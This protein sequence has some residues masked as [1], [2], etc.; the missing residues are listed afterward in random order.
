MDRS[1]VGGGAMKLCLTQIGLILILV[2]ISDFSFAQMTTTTNRNT[3]ANSLDQLGVSQDQR[4]ELFDEYNKGLP[5]CKNFPDY[6]DPFAL[7]KDQHLFREV[8]PTPEPLISSLSLDPGPSRKIT[9]E[10]KNKSLQWT[11]APLTARVFKSHLSCTD[12]L[13]SGGN[14]QFYIIFN[15]S[16]HQALPGPDQSILDISPIQLKTFNG[17]NSFTYTKTSPEGY[18]NNTTYG[19]Y[20]SG[21]SYSSQGYVMFVNEAVREITLKSFLKAYNSSWSVQ[22][23]PLATFS[24]SAASLVTENGS[25][26]CGV[27][28]TFDIVHVT[29]EGRGLISGGV[30]LNEL[31]YDDWTSGQSFIDFINRYKSNDS[32]TV[33]Y[34]RNNVKFEIIPSIYYSNIYIEKV[35]LSGGGQSADIYPG[36]FWGGKLINFPTI[37]FKPGTDYTLTIQNTYVYFSRIVNLH[38]G[39]VGIGVSGAG[40]TCEGWTNQPGYFGPTTKTCHKVSIPQHEITFKTAPKEDFYS[41]SIGDP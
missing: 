35:T 2:T 22:D 17:T 6:Q 18:L 5:T 29:H 9:V 19:S 38:T 7:A 24:L 32:E 16:A 27:P 28:S 25:S 31:I 30:R 36:L 8:T 3:L 11:R 12:R 20:N 4:R 26:A 33:S 15:E 40:V 39:H 13:S 10:C 37:D 1:S 23:N 41:L 34:V 14:G 21:P